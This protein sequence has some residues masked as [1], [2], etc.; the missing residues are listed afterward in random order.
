LRSVV[1]CI[2]C[3]PPFFALVYLIRELYVRD[4]KDV[5]LIDLE[6]ELVLLQ[7]PKIDIG[8]GR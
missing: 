8:K 2:A 1:V 6:I 5:G 3:S 4:F 7:I